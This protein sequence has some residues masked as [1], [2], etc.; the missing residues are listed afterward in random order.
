MFIDNRNALDRRKYEFSETT[1]GRFVAVSWNDMQSLARMRTSHFPQ[2][3]LDAAPDLCT[4]RIIGPFEPIS[5]LSG[6]QNG[7]VTMWFYEASSM[8]M[9]LLGFHMWSP[10]ALGFTPLY[11]VPAPT[12]LIRINTCLD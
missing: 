10:I 11:G 3:C 2:R 9:N 6:L 7:F 4:W 12:E 8:L 1:P 5:L